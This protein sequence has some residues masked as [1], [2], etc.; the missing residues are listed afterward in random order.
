MNAENQTVNR[1]GRPRI[2][3]KRLHYQNVGRGVP[4][5]TQARKLVCTAKEYF[6]QEKTNNGPLLPVAKVVQRTAAALGI[7]KNT[8]V[9]I[10]SEK[11]KNMDEGGSGEVH[12][13]NKKKLQNSVKRAWL[14]DLLYP[15]TPSDV[16][17]ATPLPLLCRVP[18]LFC[19]QFNY[20]IGDPP[21]PPTALTLSVW[22]P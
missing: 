18:V 21:H 19:N 9:K 7:N 11:K 22:T 15:V 16:D 20:R 14:A 6:Q 5:R 3:L 13:P 8:V 4:L 10:C 1:R 12:T 2:H 17:V